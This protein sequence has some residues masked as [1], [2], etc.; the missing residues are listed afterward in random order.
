VEVVALPT[1]IGA[2]YTF[3]FQNANIE[4]RV[5]WNQEN[6]VNRG[7]QLNEDYKK[8]TASSTGFIP[9]DTRGYGEASPTPSIPPTPCRLWPGGMLNST[10]RTLLRQLYF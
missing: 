9:T 6:A 10:R 5:L 4:R 8:L 1:L 7:I 3:S 2:E